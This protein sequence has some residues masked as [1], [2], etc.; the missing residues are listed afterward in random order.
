MS[1]YDNETKKTIKIDLKFVFPVCG[2]SFRIQHLTCPLVN[3]YVTITT[4][5][6]GGLSEPKIISL[7]IVMVSSSSSFVFIQ[8]RRD[9]FN[10]LQ[11]L[12]ATYFSFTISLVTPGRLQ[13]SFWFSFYTS[14][15]P[16]S[17]SS[18]NILPCWFSASVY[19]HSSTYTWG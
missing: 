13:K 3:H 17:S 5:H 18:L 9:I 15:N 1:L 6:P 4:T 14:K 10:F 11:V 8:F 12:K 7:Y 2:M 19:L 16:S